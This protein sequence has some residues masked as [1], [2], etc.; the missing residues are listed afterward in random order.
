MKCSGP[1]VPL[2][3]TRKYEVKN[4]KLTCT[5]GATFLQLYF[6]SGQAQPVTL[7][8]AITDSSL[9]LYAVCTTGSNF[10]PIGLKVQGYTD[11]GTTSDA[12][13]LVPVQLSV[14]QQGQG[15]AAPGWYDNSS[16]NSF[17]TPNFHITAKA[18][19]PPGVSGS[20]NI[21][22]D[23]NNINTVTYQDGSYTLF[24]V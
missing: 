17:T 23:I 16:P 18:N 15:F 3:V 24:Y 22:Q 21:L 4:V 14:A 12:L 13:T 2:I 20:L 6:D 5:S 19:F 8:L 9:S 1:P 10:T 11:V 7:P